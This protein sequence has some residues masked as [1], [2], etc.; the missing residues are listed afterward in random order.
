MHK[1]CSTAGICL[2][3]N[4]ALNLSKDRQIYSWSWIPKVLKQLWGIFC[5]FNYS[6]FKSWASKHE[7]LEQG[8]IKDHKTWNSTPPSQ[9]TSQ[10]WGNG[11]GCDPDDL[12]VIR[13]SFC[14]FVCGDGVFPMIVR[15][16]ISH[17]TH[18]QHLTTIQFD[19]K[20]NVRGCTD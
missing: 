9:V 15:L 5:S 14:P 20:T 19:L 13:A 4:W 6:Y 17:L 10:E 18:E 11:K 3:L 16:H 12:A 1:D 8:L 7:F 2:R